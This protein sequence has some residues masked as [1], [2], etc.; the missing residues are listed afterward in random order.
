MASH[1]SATVRETP[2]VT[3]TTQITISDALRRRAQSVI[4][5]RSTDP[6]WRSIIRYSLETSDHT[7]LSAN[8]ARYDSQ[9]QATKERRPWTVSVMFLQP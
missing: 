7:H 5:D 2:H 1:T 6:P 4:N 8:G 9:G 3:E